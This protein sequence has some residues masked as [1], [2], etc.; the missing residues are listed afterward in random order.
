MI[1]YYLMDTTKSGYSGVISSATAKHKGGS[2]S[3]TLNVAKDIALVKVQGEPVDHP[4]PNDVIIAKFTKSEQRVW[5]E[6][7]FRKQEWIVQ[8]ST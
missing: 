4:D 3:I 6:I 2:L 1:T 5:A 7:E 8:E